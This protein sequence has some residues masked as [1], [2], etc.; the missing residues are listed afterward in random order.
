MSELI[1]FPRLPALAARQLLTPVTD[2]APDA[3]RLRLDAASLTRQAGT[4]RLARDE[5]LDAVRRG[6]VRLAEA[7][8][9]PERGGTTAKATFD[10]ATA[11]WL[12]LH[13]PVPF[14]EALRDDV[15]SWLCTALA[16]DVCA[17]RFE[18]RA[19]ERF[20]GGVRNTLQRL[21]LRGQAFDRGEGV[22]D[23]WGL[24]RQ[25]TEDA[26][27]QITERPGLA[28]DRRV[29]LAIAEAWADTAARNAAG[30]MQDLARLAIRNVQATNEVLCLSALDDAALSSLC[31][32]AFTQAANALGVELADNLTGSGPTH[33]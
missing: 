31:G 2:A 14:A 8:G 19:S 13:E 30:S 1:M 10:A 24:L 17:W 21:W 23:R 27:V 15:W 3:E 11:E 16:P 25:L 29:A 32:G 20:V 33:A 12:V 6:L 7:C 18:E 4:G 26:M 28:A 5:E 22:P 9:F